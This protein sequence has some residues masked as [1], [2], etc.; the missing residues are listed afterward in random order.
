M[1]TIK[2]ETMRSLIDTIKAADKAYFEDDCPTM[3]DHAYDAL[4]NQLLALEA[5]TGTVYSDSPTQ[6][7]SGNPVSGLPVVAHT[8]PM[9]SCAK[10][11]DYNSLQK[12]VDN[13]LVMISWKE[14]GLTIVLRYDKGDLFQ[15]ITRGNGYEGEDVT[16]NAAAF[17]NVPMKI[18][19]DG[20]VEIRGECLIPWDEF[21]SINQECGGIYDH[22]RNLAAGTVRTYD[23]QKAKK[24]PLYFKAFELISPQ[25]NHKKD[26]LQTLFDWGFDVVEHFL[27]FPGVISSSVIRKN[28]FSSKYAREMSLYDEQGKPL[29]LLEDVP[30]KAAVEK[31]NPEH[32]P[33]PVDGLVLEYED[34]L[35]GSSLGSTG[36]HRKCQMAFKWQDK[37]VKT[38]LVNVLRRV[39]RTGMI[40]L[41]AQF[42]P[43]TIEHSTVEKATL[44]NL[45]IF[46]SLQLGIGDE[47][48]VYKANKI[49][50]AIAENNTRSNTYKLPM[51]CPVCKRK[52]VEKR[53]V[54]TRMLF[55]ENPACRK[56]SQLEHFCSKKAANI[57]GLSE[58]VLT[59][60]LLNGIIDSP[61]DLYTKLK[62]RK[63]EI[64]KL[65]RMGEQKYQAIINAVEKSREMEMTNFL[66]C[67]DI[68]MLGTSIG[69]VLE[70]T[71]N[72]DLQ[73]FAQAIAEHYDFRELSG[74]GDTLNDNIYAWFE[75]VQNIT[76]F[77][78]LR[79]AV[80]IKTSQA[81]SAAG[82]VLAGKTIVITGTL[83]NY[84]RS[85]AHQLIR[86]NGGTPADSVT[87]ATDFLVIAH[88]PGAT[89][90]N[91]A[92]QL[93]TPTMTEKEFLDMIS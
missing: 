46:E 21:E 30:V 3:T 39:T 20:Y 84:T 79:R 16:H 19:Y 69:K 55:C 82:G 32:Y 37:T 4:Y 24:R 67:L 26:Q 83:L 78:N 68:P 47:L 41:R 9:L 28:I 76:F 45:D 5:E 7:V 87:K 38:H 14:D 91:R 25:V 31:F 51:T 1:D 50:P 64:L 65:P 62:D 77:N 86:K 75:D 93:G 66:V 40:S 73:F 56:V 71:F 74:I 43:V 33:Y 27:Y 70:R 44:H 89:K 60:F 29:I 88:A 54:N 72:Q 18:P 2:K 49:I 52:L 63:E 22:P 61:V 15:I 80:T 59:Q 8:K 53:I 42:E 90:V 92:K 58:A 23:P 13:R 11:K 85:E 17:R 48:E 6:H 34:T 35:Y 36:H 12:F 10:V 57:N 81:A